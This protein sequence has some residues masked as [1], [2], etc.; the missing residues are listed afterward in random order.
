VIETKRLILRPWRNEDRDPFAAINADQRV[1]DWLG[2]A[3]DRAAS[4]ALID[5]FDA[6]H[7]ANGFSAWAAER[8]AD[9]R[10]I[11]MVGLSSVSADTL[12]VGPCIEIAWRLA[13]E[14]WGAG[15]ATEGAQAALDWGFANI[16]TAEIIAITATT[17]LNSQAVMRRIG[18]IPDPARDFDHPRLAADHP[19]RPHVVYVAARP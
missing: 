12:P 14:A 19:L 17:N 18:M 5:R 11:G 7:A 6:H 1:S 13:Y 16:P 10:L 8:K 15:Y 2:G 4:D 9:G 3:I